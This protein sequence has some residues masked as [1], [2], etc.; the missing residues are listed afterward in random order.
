MYA[1]NQSHWVQ[2]Y[3]NPSQTNNFTLFSDNVFLP[4]SVK[5]LMSGPGA[6]SQA[7]VNPATGLLT[8]PTENTISVGRIGTDWPLSQN[9]SEASMI[10]GGIAGDGKL[11]GWDVSSYYSHSEAMK[12]TGSTGEIDIANMFQ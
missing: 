7:L 6:T 9:F 12:K 3:A 10:R 5:A 4:A 8:G 11:F 2:D 1:D